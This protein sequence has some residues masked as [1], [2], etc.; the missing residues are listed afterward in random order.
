M[1]LK[2]TEKFNEDFAKNA[3]YNNGEYLIE[4][5][6]EVLVDKSPMQLKLKYQ[7]AKIEALKTTAIQPTLK[8]LFRGSLK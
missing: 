7:K 4:F 2:F 5:N 6:G 8:D 3:R 1:G